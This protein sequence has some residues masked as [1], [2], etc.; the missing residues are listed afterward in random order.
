[1]EKFIIAGIMIFVIVLYF[2]NNPLHHSGPFMWRRFVNWFPLG[3]T[4]AFL[5]MA[6][7]NMNVMKN[8]MGDAMTK[9]DFG[10]IVGIGTAVYGM[11]FLINGPMVDRIGGKKGM[12][13]CSLGAAVCN[14]AL[15][16]AT[17]AYLKG[18]VHFNLV[19]V[20]SILYAINMFFQ[21][22]G[23]VSIIKVKSYWFHVRERGFFGA[24]FGT[25]LS[26]GA[27]FSLDWGP[28][29]ADASKIHLE[30]PGTLQKIFRAIFAIDTGTIDAIWFV[31]FIPALVMVL[32]AL[33]DMIIIK[34]T[35]AETGFADFDT[36]DASSGEMHIEFSMRDLLMRVFT[37]PL[38]LTFAAVEFCSGVI[39]NATLQWYPVFAKEVAQ[40]GAEYFFQH[41]GF[42]LAVGGVAGGFIAGYSSDYLFQSRRAPPV[43][44]FSVVMFVLCIVMGVSM[45]TNPLVV[46]CCALALWTLVIGVH[47]LMSGTAAADFGGRKATATVS[48]ILDGFTYL[49][50]G[51]QSI[52][53]GFLLSSSWAWLPWFMAP[54]ALIAVG[55]AYRNWH[56]LPEA[57]K[58]NQHLTAV[59]LVTVTQT[60]TKTT[61]VLERE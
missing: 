16:I 6:R 38:I 36:H 55:L 59:E 20:F 48:G 15:G 26:F 8:A 29:I 31:F 35:P 32:W 47:S 50:S 34:D 1:M 37:S 42:L 56:A 2:R 58:K 61:L 30:N 21:S 44:F 11:S 39:R 27:Y 12:V 51:L 17:Y 57:A 60:V 54:F 45:M 40:P 52:S 18:G 28:A 13:I 46:G 14:I 4:Y 10:I 22:Y 49:G 33:V 7:Y 3:L 53:L 23:A 25:L 5:Y 43:L 41:W 9:A 24:I 19:V